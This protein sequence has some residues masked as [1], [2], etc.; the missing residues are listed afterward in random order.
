[1]KMKLARLIDSGFQNSVRTLM[2]QPLPLKAA[3]KLRGVVKKAEAELTQ[4]EEMRK[5]ALQKYGK[6]KEDGTLDT[7]ETNNVQFET[8]ETL[9]VFLK[10]IGDLT[11]VDVDMPAITLTELGDDIRLSTEDLM[12]LEG[13]IVD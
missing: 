11:N 10:D 8:Q 12:N 4:Y 1:M 7:T 9:Q 2:K 5:E 13:L 6:K 3:Y